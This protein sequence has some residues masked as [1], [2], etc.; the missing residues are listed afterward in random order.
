MKCETVKQELPNTI[1][2]YLQEL[3][4]D[5]VNTIVIEHTYTTLM[6]FAAYSILSNTT[7]LVLLTTLNYIVLKYIYC[8]TSG[9]VMI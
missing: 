5:K 3:G 6:K 8:L 4:F 2:F 1:P 9:I 7:T